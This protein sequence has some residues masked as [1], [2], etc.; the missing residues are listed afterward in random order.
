MGERAQEYDAPAS[1]ER[2]GVGINPSRIFVGN[3][4]NSRLSAR[5]AVPEHPERGGT[6]DQAVSDRESG[7]QMRHGLEDLPPLRSASG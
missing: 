7:R 4:I 5:A 3:V 6:K 2:R 1:Y